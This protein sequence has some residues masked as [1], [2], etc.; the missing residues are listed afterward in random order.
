MTPIVPDKWPP[1]IEDAAR[2]RYIRWRDFLCTI[3]M[4]LL[5]VWLCRRGL[6]ATWHDILYLLGHVP[7][8]HAGWVRL[9]A[10]LHPYFGV[11][12]LFGIWQ[13]IWITTTVWRKH[14]YSRRPQPA[15][16]S[17]E[18]EA[19]RINRT[20]TDLSEWRTMKICVVHFDQKGDPVIVVKAPPPL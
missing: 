3:A 13:V 5:L 10:Q 8:R 17:P 20:A 2:P 16:L 15:P 9:W 12:A 18:E 1:I 6:H 14:L 11:I 7:T 4:W 19:R